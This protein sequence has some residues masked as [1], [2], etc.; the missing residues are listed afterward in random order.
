MVGKMEGKW[1][2]NIKEKQWRQFQGNVGENVGKMWGK[3]GGLWW[4]VGESGGNS[5]EKTEGNLGK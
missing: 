2:E 1:K 3:C 5:R 4:N